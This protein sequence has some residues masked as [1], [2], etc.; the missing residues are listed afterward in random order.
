MY[1]SMVIKKEHYKRKQLVSSD[2][3][4]REFLMF[5]RLLSLLALAA[6]TVG[7]GMWLLGGPVQWR[8]LLG[9]LIAGSVLVG[10]TELVGRWINPI[11]ERV[12]SW[13]TSAPKK[14]G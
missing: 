12:I 9:G 10:V 4:K 13:R 14:Q 11:I 6:I 5:R 2:W 8:T 7:V 3:A 1:V